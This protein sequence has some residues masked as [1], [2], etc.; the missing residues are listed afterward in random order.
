MQRKCNKCRGKGSYRLT[1]YEHRR[2][3]SRC[4]GTGVMDRQTKA[5][6]RFRRAAREYQPIVTD[7]D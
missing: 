6:K 1:A 4:R 5:E 3:C 7:R 2:S